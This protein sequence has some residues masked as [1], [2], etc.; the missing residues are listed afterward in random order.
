MPMCHNSEY[1][2]RAFD[3]AKKVNFV[4]WHTFTT[5]YQFLKS[6]RQKKVHFRILTV[7]R[8]SGDDI[9]LGQK[10]IFYYLLFA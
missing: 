7:N 1:G 6:V 3:C 4:K 9:Y 5:I 2:K 10:R 8:L